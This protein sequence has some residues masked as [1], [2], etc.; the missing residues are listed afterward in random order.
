ME[1]EYNPQRY[2]SLTEF[3]EKWNDRYPWD[4]WWRKK[5]KIPFGSKQH[6]KMCHI[7]MMLEFIESKMMKR[8]EREMEERKQMEEDE[9]LGLSM[10]NKTSISMNRKEIDEVFDNIDLNEFN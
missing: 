2:V 5:Y 8:R 10:T 1:N 3:I 6:K 9:E 7:D 4:L